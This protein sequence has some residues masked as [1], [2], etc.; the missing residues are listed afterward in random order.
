MERRAATSENCRCWNRMEQTGEISTVWR[1]QGWVE[2]E[3]NTLPTVRKPL[4]G[5]TGQKQFSQFNKFQTHSVFSTA[6]CQKYARY[7]SHK[8]E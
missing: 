4:S 2:L 7:Q 6:I 1:K 5:N 3:K 8:E